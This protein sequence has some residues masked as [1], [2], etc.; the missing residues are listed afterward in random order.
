MKK[1]DFKVYNDNKLIGILS[2]KNFIYSFYYTD[3]SAVLPAFPEVKLYKSDRLFNMFKNRVPNKN[4][5][6]V[7]KLID[8]HNLDR[9]CLDLELLKFTGGRLPTDKLSLKIKGGIKM[10]I[11]NEVQLKDPIKVYSVINQWMMVVGEDFIDNNENFIDGHDILDWLYKSN[12]IS[13]NNYDNIVEKN[14]VGIQYLLLGYKTGLSYRGDCEFPA[15][16]KGY[17]IISEYISESKKLR[18]QFIF[19]FCTSCNTENGEEF[20]G[21]MLESY[22][23]KDGYPICSHIEDYDLEVGTISKNDWINKKHDTEF[24]FADEYIFLASLNFEEVD[25]LVV[26]LNN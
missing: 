19:N 17:Q 18:E 10:I 9:N 4:R 5:R 24:S 23:A 2:Y 3:N 8:Y 13:K 11:K 16:D 15:I 22:D 20:R 1:Y 12:H 7:K 21:G 26:K 6:G 25:D 14:E